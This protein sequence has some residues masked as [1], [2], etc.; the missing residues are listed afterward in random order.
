MWRTRASRVHTDHG[1]GMDL[2]RLV[3]KRSCFFTSMEERD[4]KATDCSS[5][6]YSMAQMQP[7]ESCQ[8]GHRSRKLVVGERWKQ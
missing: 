5:G 6:F 1:A 4:V 3:F 2:D 8:L 7:L